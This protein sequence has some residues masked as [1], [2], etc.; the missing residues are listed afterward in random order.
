MAKQFARI[1]KEIVIAVRAGGPDPNSNP[2]LRRIVQNA[3]AVNMPKKP[4]PER[5][6]R[7]TSPLRRAERPPAQLSKGLT[8]SIPQPAKSRTLR[9]ATAKP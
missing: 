1:G 4:R 5:A 9:V 8:I 7:P 2:R 3:S 6:L